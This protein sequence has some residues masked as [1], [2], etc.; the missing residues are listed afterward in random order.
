MALL[1]IGKEEVEEEE[2]EEEQHQ[3]DDLHPPLKMPF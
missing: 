3:R 2:Y 1:L